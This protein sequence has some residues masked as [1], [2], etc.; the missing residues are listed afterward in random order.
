MGVKRY[1][2]NLVPAI[3]AVFVVVFSVHVVCEAYFKIPVLIRP[4]WGDTFETGDGDFDW[5]YVMGFPKKKQ[6]F[7]IQIASDSGFENI[8]KTKTVKDKHIRFERLFMK[9]G[10]Y[11]FRTRAVIDGK[12]YRW[13]RPVKFYG[14]E[15]LEG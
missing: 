11:Y 7:I 4:Q 6:T 15:G 10:S 2:P 13:S 14:A 3:C 12:K 5:N 1:L 8:I 9:K